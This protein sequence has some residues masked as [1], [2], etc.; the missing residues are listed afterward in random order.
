MTIR[1]LGLVVTC[2]L[3][4]GQ[5]S[6]QAQ[7]YVYVANSYYLSPPAV[8]APVFTAPVPVGVPAPGYV[9]P[10]AYPGYYVAPAPVVSLPVLTVPTYVRPVTPVLVPATVIGP[11]YYSFHSY[12]GPF[13]S[14]TREVFRY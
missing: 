5:S 3:L 10:V 13:V 14:R 12:H 2:L 7:G 1:I 8:V 4:T 9:V 6:A 11:R